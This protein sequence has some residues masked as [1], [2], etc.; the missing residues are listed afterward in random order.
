MTKCFLTLDLFY[1]FG[2]GEVKVAG[3]DGDVFLD[4]REQ[5]GCRVVVGLDDLCLDRHAVGIDPE[6][7]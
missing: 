4:V 7:G 6:L 1:A 2:E 3:A 5:D